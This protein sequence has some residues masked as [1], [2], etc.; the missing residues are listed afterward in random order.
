MKIIHFSTFVFLFL[1]GQA[2]AAAPECR[3]QKVEQSTAEMCLLRGSAFQ[4]DVYT[5]KLDKVLIFALVD[6]FSENVTLEHVIPEGLTIE[7]PLSRQ[8]GKSVKITGG[9][10]PESKD[11]AEVARLCNFSWG[12]FQVVKDV[13]FEFK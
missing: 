6:D 7:F 4:H 2:F 9:C 5:L 10:V 3:Q 8:E 11:G 13:R 12:R 1:T